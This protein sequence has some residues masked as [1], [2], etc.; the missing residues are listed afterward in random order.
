ME[1]TRTSLELANTVLG[2]GSRRVDLLDSPA[3][4]VRWL[5]GIEPELGPAPAETGLRLADFRSL[6]EAIRSLF[7]AS[8]TGETVSPEAVETV[9][10]VSAAVSA[11][12]SLD[13]S[14]PRVPVVVEVPSAGSRTAE[15]LA[16]LSRSAI[17]LVGGPDRERLR[18]CG[19]SGCGRF[20][21]ASRPSQVWCSPACGNR[22]RVARH[23]ARRRVARS[24]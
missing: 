16:L 13:A 21:L 11:Y 3:D 17:S 12:P 24:T 18:S 6:R 4:L 14:D 20:F 8:A 7:G 22:A 5:E 9:N 19:G 23:H 2:G 15:I 10:S 1:R